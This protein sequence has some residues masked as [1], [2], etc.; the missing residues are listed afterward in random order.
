MVKLSFTAQNPMPILHEPVVVDF[1]I[2]NGLSESL[3]FDLGHDRTGNFEFTITRPDGSVVR[4]PRLN[5][6][7]LGRLGKMTLAPGQS[8][9]QRLLLN[10]WLEFAQPGEYRID[11]ALAGN[12]TRGTGGPV[13][14]E[15]AATINLRILP[16]NPQ[17]LEKISEQLAATATAGNAATAIDASVALSHVQDP[18][19]VPQL[20]MALQDGIR[21]VQRN[22]ASGLA[23]IAN[24][25]AI[26]ALIARLKTGDAELSDYIRVLLRGVRSKT[27]DREIQ[28]MIDAAL[29]GSG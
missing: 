7:G 2:E 6:E 8:Y 13:Q 11:A 5:P 12:F 29:K 3:S 22:A 16:A 14:T 28:T 17:V 26:E 23:G 1:T 19:A 21:Q 15:R 25:P 9:I 4:P 27:V 18:V 10:R 20:V 24:R